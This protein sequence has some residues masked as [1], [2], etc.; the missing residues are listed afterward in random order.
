VAPSNV[1]DASM[2]NYNADLFD[3]AVIDASGDGKSWSWVG[4]SDDPECAPA[5]YLDAV[6]KVA[7]LGE[8]EEDAA[9]LTALEAKLGIDASGL[10]LVDLGKDHLRDHDV[11]VGEPVD[12]IGVGE[13]DVRIDD[14]GA[15]DAPLSSDRVGRLTSI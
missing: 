10:Q 1:G 9:H 7:L 2:P 13:Q 15:H 12:D 8:L 6:V 14:Y 4:Q 5:G 3:A 11:R